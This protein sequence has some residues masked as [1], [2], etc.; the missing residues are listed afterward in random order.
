ML[1]QR[2]FMTGTMLTGSSL[3]SNSLSVHSK[4]LILSDNV[5][6]FRFIYGRY[7]PLNERN[8]HKMLLHQRARLYHR[9]EVELDVEGILASIKNRGFTYDVIYDE[10]MNYYL[11]G[12][13]KEIWGDDPTLQWREIP[14]FLKIF[15]QGK[16][17][18]ILRDPR[19]VVTSNKKVTVTTNN[20]Y[21]NAIFNGIDSLNYA[22]R[23][24]ASLSPESYFC[25]RYEDVATNPE[26]WIK[27]LCDFLEV[28]FETA[29][30]QPE[31]WEGMLDDK[32]VT[33][34][35]SSFDGKTVVG[36]SPE[37]ASRWKNIIEK[38]ELCLVESIAGD[39]LTR[40]GY[41]LTGNNFSSSDF[42]RALAEIK[43]ND[44]VFKNFINYMQ[45]GEGSN[46]FPLDPT[47]YR[48][49]GVSI[50]KNLFK[51][52]PMAKAYLEEMEEINKRFGA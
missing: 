27:K 18:H 14:V 50:T 37:R 36:F 22:S 3:L 29:M 13:N 25:L 4:I 11:R 16:V 19:A 41:E 34:G 8:V 9:F 28:N 35:R 45:T 46:Q 43:K 21:L 1:K 5:H 51:D 17:I 42:A 47:D 2:I 44:V 49:W 30:L 26:V 15:P 39:I 40:H 12:T 38:W 33:L 52:T 6:F 48:S 32:L 23:L 20:G 7:E 24:K 10:S 31:K